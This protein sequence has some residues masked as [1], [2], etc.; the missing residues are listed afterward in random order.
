MPTAHKGEMMLVVEARTCD[1]PAD[2]RFDYWCNLTAES[3]LPSTLSSAHT[4]NFEAELRLID[5]GTVQLTKLRYPP[6]QSLRTPQL[7]RRSDPECYQ[8]MLTL[9]GGHLLTQGGRDVVG[10]AGELL[11]YDTSRPWHGTAWSD[12]GHIS[13]IMLQLPRT[14]LP[15]PERK[16]RSL[17]AGRLP[18]GDG[19]GALLAGFLQQLSADAHTYTA[20]DASRLAA[21]TVDLLAAV[22]ARHLDTEEVLS[23]RRW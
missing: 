14:L 20:S 2:E 7:V 21:V 19:V 11:L 16:V 18:A 4:A 3:L 5:L 8:V 10:A 23:F 1:L 15:L 17:S 6:L 12:S 9:R 13:G 22:C